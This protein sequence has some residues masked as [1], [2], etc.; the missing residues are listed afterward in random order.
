MCCKRGSI[1]PGIDVPSSVQSHLVLY[2]A[3]PRHTH[4]HK[5]LSATIL[6]FRSSNVIRRPHLHA[7]LWQLC[8]RPIWATLRCKSGGAKE[9]RIQHW[10]KCTKPTFRSDGLGVRLSHSMSP[11]SFILTRPWLQIGSSPIPGRPGSCDT[12]GR[13]FLINI[14]YC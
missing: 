11:D 13:Q 5:E 12:Y 4:T 2:R 6:G 9:L 1:M 7:W 8:V 14:I 3:P 10:N